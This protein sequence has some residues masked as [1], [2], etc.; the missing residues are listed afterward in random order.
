MHILLVD[1]DAESR[2]YFA[3]FLRELQCQVT[4]K[5]DGDEALKAIMAKPFHLVLTDIKMPRMS[6]LEL[7]Q[8]I[9]QLPHRENTPVVLFTGY[10][11]IMTRTEAL[12]AGAYDYLLKPVSVEWLARFIEQLSTRYKTESIFPVGGEQEMEI[13]TLIERLNSD[14]EKERAFAAEDIGY[15]NLTPAIEALVK[16]LQIEP[17]RFVQ[18]VI[19]N[20]LKSMKAADLAEKVI[21]LLYSDDAF[22][23]NAGIDILTYQGEQ[24]VIGLQRLLHNNDKDVRK[25]ALDIIFQINN[26][27]TP[28]MVAEAL[29]DPELNIVITAVEYL[30]RL[31]ASAYIERIHRI[32]TTADNLLLRCTCLEA[33]SIIG[34]QDTVKVVAS[35]YPDPGSINELELYSLVKFVGR[36]GSE[37]HLPLIIPLMVEK[38]DT[39]TK[40]II[41]AVD[42]ILRRSGRNELPDELV[43]AL[44]N[45]IATNIN[46][47]NKYELLVLLAR[48]TN[49]AIFPLLLNYASSTNALVCLGAVEG[50]GLYNNPAAL[51]YLEKLR[52]QVDNVD[53]L[54][55]LDRSIELLRNIS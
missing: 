7:L 10:A 43:S 37:E 42:S 28:G 20:A 22:I 49:E 14:D 34:N 47:I 44:A 18:E 12:D 32:F 11:D 36:Q 26:R 35:L 52:D 31:E 40:E 45:Y 3:D 54:E 4:E 33:M 38:G 55:A 16:R 8:N 1:D 6:G 30:G 9:H 15:D 24:A 5:G 19:T 21:P 17:S 48:Y 50:L 29:E 2:R 27:Y 46:D 23:R 41:N 39:M 53:I 25:F 13:Q 51:R